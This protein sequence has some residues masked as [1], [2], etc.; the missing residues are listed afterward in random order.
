MGKSDQNLLCQLHNI[1]LYFKTIEPS[2][3]D[4]GLF[5]GTMA[6]SSGANDTQST[7]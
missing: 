3:L 1:A 5:C 4:S 6:P 7:V 2:L